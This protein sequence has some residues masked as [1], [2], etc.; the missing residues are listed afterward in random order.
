MEGVFHVSPLPISQRVPELELLLQMTL[1]Y[2]VID[3]V[4]P[5]AQTP[6]GQMSIVS[7]IHGAPG[8]EQR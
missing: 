4:T 1:V 3:R 5:L 6:L 2:L 8:N 7:I